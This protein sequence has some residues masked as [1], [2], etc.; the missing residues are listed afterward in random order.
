MKKARKK[1]AKLTPK[2]Q[3]GLLNRKLY[4]K[5]F[6]ELKAK[7]DKAYKRLQSSMK[8]KSDPAT[9]LRH[10][11][12]LLLLLGEANYMAKECARLAKAKAKRK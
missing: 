3:S 10:R 8:K 9:L 1:R 2:E 4:W 5:A 7:A 6:R 11:N 12:E